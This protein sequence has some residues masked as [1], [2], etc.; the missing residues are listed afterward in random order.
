M[1]K[2]LLAFLLF[3]PCLAPGQRQPIVMLGVHGSADMCNLLMKDVPEPP[4]T[5]DSLRLYLNPGFGHTQGL[6]FSLKIIEHLRIETA[7]ALSRSAISLG[8][9]QRGLD[10]TGMLWM[11]FRT[12]ELPLLLQFYA[13]NEKLQFIA[14]AGLELNFILGYLL[15]AEYHFGQEPTFFEE[16]R[17]NGR[18]IIPIPALKGNA[19]IHWQISP[20]FFLRPA[21]SFR[22]IPPIADISGAKIGGSQLGLQIA[23]GWCPS[24]S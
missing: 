24:G 4:S 11:S 13:G 22:F 17:H 23:V 15:R 18:H 6:M 5:A 16:E 10:S 14:G 19:G 1:P 12:L 21:L 20:G 2:K 3:L 7:P 8:P 9:V